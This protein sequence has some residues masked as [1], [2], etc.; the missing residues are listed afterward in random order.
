MESI[1]KILK[2]FPSAIYPVIFRRYHDQDFIFIVTHIINHQLRVRMGNNQWK[3]I[4]LKIKKIIDVLRVHN[5]TNI[6]KPGG[7][8]IQTLTVEVV[9]TK[10]AENSKLSMSVC[11]FQSMKSPVKLNSRL[12][13]FFCYIT[14]FVISPV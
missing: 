2:N 14:W 12:S 9:P 3:L 11:N 5:K 13:K 1:C 6:T 7:N 10:S 8:Q 4:K